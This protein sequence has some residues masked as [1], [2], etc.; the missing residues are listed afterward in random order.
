MTVLRGSAGP[1]SKIALGWHQRGLSVM[2]AGSGARV[3]EMG[4]VQIVRGGRGRVLAVRRLTVRDVG[5]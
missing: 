3:R 5:L 2:R 1:E 4:V